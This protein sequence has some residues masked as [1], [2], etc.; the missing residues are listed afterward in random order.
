[1]RFGGNDREEHFLC[2]NKKGEMVEDRCP[3][4]ALLIKL[5]SFL[6]LNPDMIACQNVYAL[7][8]FF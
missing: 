7:A 2:K 4:F 5:D 8:G 1:M 3:V 6:F